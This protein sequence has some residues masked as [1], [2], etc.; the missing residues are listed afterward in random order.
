M[1]AYLATEFL[2]SI[3]ELKR[4]HA[5]GVGDGVLSRSE[6]FLL[7][8]LHEIAYPSGEGLCHKGVHVSRICAHM[9]VSMPAVSQM[10]RALEKKQLIVRKMDVEDR[11]K[12]TV[13]I[14]PR[15]AELMHE[16]RRRF[17][18]GLCRVV[19]QLGEKDTQ[20]FIRLCSRI[21]DILEETR[22]NNHERKD[23]S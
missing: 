6:F 15:G 4:L 22:A 14:T 11:R 7:R 1:D 17:E 10:L 12:I 2:E 21:K 9:R 23:R 5:G 16:T 13:S 20:E 18:E 8:A 19:S 3:N